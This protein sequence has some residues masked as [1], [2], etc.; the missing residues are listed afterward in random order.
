MIFK[1]IAKW[2]SFAL[3]L[4]MVS[5][6]QIQNVYAKSN[7]IEIGNSISGQGDKTYTFKLSEKMK[8]KIDI[9]VEE[10]NDS[11]N[12]ELYDYMD[13][14]NYINFDLSNANDYGYISELSIDAGKTISK[15]FTLDAGTYNINIWA[16][17]E[18]L[19]YNFL[20]N[21]I[22][23]YSSKISLTNELTILAKG[24]KT[25]KVKNEQK[26]SL[27]GKVT[28]S[29]SNKKI[30][31]VDSKG[32]VKGIKAGTCYISVKTKYSNT[33]KCKIIVKARPQLYIKEAT[34]GINSAGGV[35]PY[36]ALENNFN[37]TIKYIYF[38]SYFYNTVGDPAYCEIKNTYHQTLQITGPLK[39]G[40]SE[41]YYWDPVIYNYSTGKMYIKTVKII[42][43]DGTTKTLSI[44][45][46]Y[47]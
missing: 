43:M 24:N 30:A 47:K 29:S 22:S 20:I 19:S 2:I 46:S 32:N 17:P 10:K 44:K 26:G 45:K 41:S 15:I 40:A 33:V 36:I 21:D 35:E 28:W 3:V 27:L 38:E 1:R 5:T 34:F 13:Y 8:I 16:E 31:T 23:T 7:I 39:K 9:S 11:D 12:D 37:K 25:L 18:D 6:L 14:E 42:F 4:V